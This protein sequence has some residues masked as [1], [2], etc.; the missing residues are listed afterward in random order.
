MFVLKLSGIQIWNKYLSRIRK[1][2]SEILLFFQKKHVP[3]IKI[4]LPY[5]SHIVKWFIVK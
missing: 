3:K 4:I 5:Y 1:T 2:I